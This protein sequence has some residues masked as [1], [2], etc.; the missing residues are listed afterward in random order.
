MVA[1]LLWLA[2]L[3]AGS[4]APNSAAAAPA[5]AGAS[6][7]WG[8]LTVTP[9]YLEAP[10]ALIEA[11]SKP[12]QVPLWHFDSST[13]DSLRP[14]L[15]ALGLT[16]AQLDTLLIPARIRQDKG[17]VSLLPAPD[18][19]LGLTP[20]VRQAL[21]ESL[22]QSPRN[23]FHASPLLIYGEV[24]DW[25]RD[26]HLSPAQRNLWRRLLWQRHGRPAFSDISLLTQLSA[27]S[28]EMTAARSAMTR[29]LTYTVTVLPTPGAAPDAFLA[30]WGAGQRNTDAGPLLR[31]LLE[32]SDRNG[33]DLALLL[34]SLARERLYTYPSLSDAVAGRLPDCQWTSLNF[35][36]ENPQRYYIDGRNSFLELTQNY[37]AIPRPSQ[38]GDLVCFV[39]PEG[40]VVHS[41]VQV[42]DDLVFTKN[43]ESVFMPWILMRLS[44]L[45][46]LYGEDGRNRL[47]FFRLKP[48]AP[49]N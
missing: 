9:L 24:E 48:T 3:T 6:A 19:I 15:S 43:G 28:A 23:H 4:A 42:C 5:A 33:I 37:E 18:L 44:D 10:N 41:C 29:V 45:H 27:S 13:P 11:I 30:Y 38:L 2:C 49:A 16:A 8:L 36:A 1:G 39:N 32:R 34:P 17:G 47:A 20:A 14:R 35:F 22:A 26:S 7:P 31:A 25:L 40:V 21:Y 46:A 12:D